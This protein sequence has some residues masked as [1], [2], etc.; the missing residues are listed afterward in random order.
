MNMFKKKL[1]RLLKYEGYITGDDQKWTYDYTWEDFEQAVRI[2]TA[3]YD[4]IR[5]DIQT[6]CWRGDSPYKDWYT[7]DQI[8]AIFNNPCMIP[9][10]GFS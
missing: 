3:P 8:K 1:P 4:P 9:P 2:T 10:R 5:G 6:S 7:L